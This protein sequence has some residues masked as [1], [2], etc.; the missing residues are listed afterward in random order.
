[1]SKDGFEA[2]RR[3]LLE[4]TASVS[5]RDFGALSLEL[6]HFQLEYNPLYRAYADLSG[7]LA[8]P[9]QQ[10]ADIPM[11]PISFFK[12]HEVQTGVWSPQQIFS[13]SGTTGQTTSRHLVRDTGHYL[14]NARRCFE[15]FYG[16]VTDWCFLAL[17]PS[18]L[19]RSGSSLIAMADDFIRRSRYPESGFFLYD[20]A[21]L[22]AAVAVVRQQNI[23]TIL[24]GVSFALLDWAE[25]GPPELEH[26]TVMDTGGM[27]GRR[28]EWTRQ[29][30]HQVLT[31][32]FRTPAI[33][34]EYGMTELFS[35][36]YSRGEGRYYPGPTMRVLA[37][38]INDPFSA[39]EPGKTGVLNIID[40]AN[41]DSCAFIAT[42]DLGRVHADGSFEV[43]G[44]LDYSDIRGCNLLYL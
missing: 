16:P 10:P 32:A 7:R 4:K 11:L 37:R 24:L 44:R 14:A 35:Q 31:T 5:G 21:A 38:E 9:P 40:L 17:L 42:D 34:S 22:E 15:T 1:M 8:D 25:A 30:L 41:V 39:V 13:S 3:H 2:M 12:T 20:R 18:Y 26:L 27:K 36:A 43:L 6:Y 29:E 23:P 19:E 28:K 33:H